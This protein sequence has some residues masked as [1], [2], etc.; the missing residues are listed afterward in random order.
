MAS[1]HDILSDTR[2]YIA[3]NFSKI[4][5]EIMTVTGCSASEAI[6]QYNELLSDALKQEEDAFLESMG[7]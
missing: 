2:Q 7:L 1:V 3:N 6:K 5:H 4:V